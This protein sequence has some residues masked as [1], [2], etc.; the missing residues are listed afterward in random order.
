VS[1]STAR[2]FFMREKSGKRRKRIS[3]PGF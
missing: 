1:R 2:K 3:V